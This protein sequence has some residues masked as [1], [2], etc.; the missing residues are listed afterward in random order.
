MRCCQ[1][2][3]GMQSPLRSR[4]PRER[5]VRSPPS[6]RSP[7]H[8]SLDR[9]AHYQ[10]SGSPRPLPGT[11]A[12]RRSV[13]PGRARR[14]SLRDKGLVRNPQCCILRESLFI[15]TRQPGHCVHQIC[16][17]GPCGASVC[18]ILTP[19][20]HEI[21]YDS[22][23]QC[24]HGYDGS[25]IEHSPKTPTA[26]SGRILR[27]RTDPVVACLTATWLAFFADVLLV[28]RCDWS[29]VRW[30]RL[31]LGHGVTFCILAAR[32]SRNWSVTA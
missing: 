3:D 14:T 26:R 27:T 19:C 24:Q 11:G 18:A 1:R 30:R 5:D 31:I 17:L 15:K 21:C 20:I 7:C 12:R 29:R 6:K 10:L 2:C 28:L 4:L 22:K 23:R 25:S 9:Y 32:V 16:E 13:Q 8:S